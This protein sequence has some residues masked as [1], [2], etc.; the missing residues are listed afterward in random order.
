ML[1]ILKKSYKIELKMDTK[2][3]WLFLILLSTSLSQNVIQGESVKLGDK[4]NTIDF[5]KWDPSIP[6]LSV[7]SFFV[8]DAEEFKNYKKE[9]NVFILQVSKSSWKECWKGELMLKQL[10]TLFEMGKIAYRQKKIP[11]VRIDLDKTPKM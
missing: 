11:I 3:F 4:S 7:G 9:Q 10:K 5:E 1:I 8:E 6:N 2:I